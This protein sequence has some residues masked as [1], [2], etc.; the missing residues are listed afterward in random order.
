[1]PAQPTASSCS[2]SDLLISSCQTTQTSSKYKFVFTECN[3]PTIDSIPSLNGTSGDVLTINGNGFSANSCENEI[4]IG[5]Y[6][7]PVTSSSTTEINCTIGYGSGLEP[8]KAYKI[9]VRQKNVGNAIQNNLY[10]FK[11][12]PQISSII[13]SIGI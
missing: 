5:T 13:P 2:G 4:F 10:E 8:N 11:L 9:E 3:V 6:K 7:C 12:L 1:M